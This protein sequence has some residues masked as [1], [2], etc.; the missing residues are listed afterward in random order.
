[1]ATSVT[2]HQTCL[3]MLYTHSIRIS[4]VEEKLLG[5]AYVLHLPAIRM[6]YYAPTAT[7]LAVAACCKG[8]IGAAGVQKDRIRIPCYVA[9][10]TL[11]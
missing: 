6:Q 2:Q 9:A 1:M 7:W 10:S 3:K 11:L 5:A 4:G 8:L